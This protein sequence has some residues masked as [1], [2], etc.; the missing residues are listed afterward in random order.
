M[1]K[2]KWMAQAIS[3]TGEIH[4]NTE[5]LLKDLLMELNGTI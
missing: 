4:E 1:D 2:I 5:F 3:K